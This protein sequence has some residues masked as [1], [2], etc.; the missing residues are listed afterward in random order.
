M[1]EAERQSNLP[2]PQLRVLNFIARLG[3]LNGDLSQH[4]CTLGFEFL[5]QMPPSVPP[6]R[7]GWRWTP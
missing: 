1:G 5:G 2:F 4:W 7:A 3:L 6:K